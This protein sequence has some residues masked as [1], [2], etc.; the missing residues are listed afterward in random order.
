MYCVCFAAF[1]REVN[2]SQFRVHFTKE[3]EGGTTA[4]TRSSC[5]K[6]RTGGEHRVYIEQ[7][8][9]YLAKKCIKQIAAATAL[10]NAINDDDNSFPSSSQDSKREILQNAIHLSPQLDKLW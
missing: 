10:H 7:R 3:S 2:S 4:T 9:L 1:Q 5:T 6:V 8:D